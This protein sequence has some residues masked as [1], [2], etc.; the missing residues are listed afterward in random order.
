MSSAPKFTPSI[1]SWTPTTPIL[2][3]AEAWKKTS[4]P[5]SVLSWVG[6]MTETVGGVVSGAGALSTVIESVAVAVFPA[7]SR[8]TADS[9]WAA[10]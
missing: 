8:A 7:A 3:V 10:F 2:S 9:V 4:L 6:L 1:F 5:E